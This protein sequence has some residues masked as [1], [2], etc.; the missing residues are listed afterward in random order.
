MRLGAARP[1]GFPARTPTNGGGHVPSPRTARAFAVCVQNGRTQVLDT[2]DGRD[3]L[4][5]TTTPEGYS[6]SVMFSPDSSTLI[7]TGVWL[8]HSIRLWDA[9]S[10]EPQGSLEGHNWVSDLVFTPDG[11]QLIASCGSTIR[12]WDWADRKPAG[13]LRGHLDGIYGMTMSPD[14]RTLASGCVDGSVYLWNP[15]NSSQHRAY[16]TLQSPAIFWNAGMFTPDGQSILG[17]ET[18]GAVGFWD[19]S[20]LKETR[21]LWPNSTNQPLAISPD[22][23]WV[24]RAE[25]NGNL[26]V[27]GVASGLERTNFV[28]APGQLGDVRFTHNAKFLVTLNGPL[29]N[30]VLEVWDTGNWQR[31]KYPC[32]PARGRQK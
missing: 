2:K 3:R 23:N 16:R 26:S 5:I 21:R 11:S 24:V 12:L 27:W 15:T 29:T 14:G 19:V 22:A 6:I 30:L 28:A 1:L 9:H 7:T 20:T 10:G 31:I 4:N 32:T 8:D 13:F 18:G 17:I 25:N